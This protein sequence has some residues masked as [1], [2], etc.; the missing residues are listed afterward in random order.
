MAYFKKI[1]DDPDGQQSLA[2]WLDQKDELLAGRTPRVPG[3]GLSV[4]D[5]CNRFLTHK[6]HHRETGELSDRSFRS[7]TRRV[8]GS[9]GF[10]A[11]TASWLT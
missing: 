5:A 2:S 4:M 8:Y 1:A 6:K 7:T 11:R 3:D 9:S 10:S